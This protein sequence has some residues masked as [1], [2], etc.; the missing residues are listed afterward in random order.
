M[1]QHI[2]GQTSP[3]AHRD[4]QICTFEEGR[5]HLGAQHTWMGHP[6]S[7]PGKLHTNQQ[8]LLQ[9]FVSNPPAWSQIS[10]KYVGIFCFTELIS[11]WEPQLAHSSTEGAVREES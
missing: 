11:V 1:S 3:Q 6:K 7:H 2:L 8:Q 4:D 9:I 10:I 5:Q